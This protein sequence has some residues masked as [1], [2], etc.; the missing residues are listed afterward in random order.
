MGDIFFLRYC[1]EKELRL[2][3]YLFSENV[4]LIRVSEM[5]NARF[6]VISVITSIGKN[7][8]SLSS[9]ATWA[10]LTLISVIRTDKGTL[11]VASGRQP[12]PPTRH[13]FSRLKSLPFFSPLI[14]FISILFSNSFA[15]LSRMFWTL[16]VL[17]WSVLSLL[18]THGCYLH[19]LNT[20]SGF[21]H[22][23]FYLLINRYLFVFPCLFCF[24]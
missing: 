7:F 1:V 3:F 12:S 20:N 5:N 15:F 18:E 17:K 9:V 24:A 13:E 21:P 11:G 16:L 19:L 4:R 2:S 22:L 23:Y 6:Y 8:A 10:L 14:T